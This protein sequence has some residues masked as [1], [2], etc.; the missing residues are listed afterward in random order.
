MRVLK[1]LFVI[2]LVVLL[3]FVTQTGGVIFLLSLFVFPIVAKFSEWPWLRALFKASSFILIYLIFTFAIVPY[4]APLFGRVPLP[5]FEQDHV[6][7][8]NFWTCILNRNYVRRELRDITFRVAEKM[9]A[10]FPGTKVNYLDANFPF[11]NEFPLLP[12]RSHDDGK[13]LDISFQYNDSNTGE[14]TNDVP[15]FIG[16]GICEGPK[17]GE[18]DRPKA[19]V[20]KGYW[21]YSLLPD[22]VS[23]DNKKNFVFSNR[24]NKE[25]VNG[26]AAEQ[27][28]GKIFIEPHLK[29]RLG[30]GSRKIRFHGCQAVRHDDHIHAE[31]R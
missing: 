16:Y 20:S 14:I 6:R 13:K 1:L 18:E 22:L 21:Q 28:L 25:L 31:L 23:Q 9:N 2:V 7:P 26:F 27:A 17:T 29:A 5:R 12:H 24:R 15:S 11:I 3:T 30:L 4:V 8:A 10:K 19:C